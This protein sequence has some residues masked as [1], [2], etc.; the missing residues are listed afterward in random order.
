[1]ILIL[2]GATDG[3]QPDVCAVLDRKGAKYA[4]LDTAAFPQSV[5]VT[6]RYSYGERDSASLQI[7]EQ[8]IDLVQVRAVWYRRPTPP[9][10]D[11]GLAE[12]DRQ[13]VAREA[14]HVFSGLWHSLRNRFWVNPYDASRAVEH[15]PYQLRMA[16]DVGFDVPRTLITNEPHEALEFFD[17]CAEGMIYKTFSGHARITDDT[18]YAI[19]TS[20][21]ARADLVARC[22][23]I[24]L[25]PCIFQEYVPKKVELR[26]TVIGKRIFA[27]E[28]DSQSRERT[29]DDWRRDSL[30]SHPAMWPTELPP[31]QQTLVHEMMNR[32]GL[33]FGCFD[34]VRTPD[35][36]YVFL[37]LNPNG[38]W[39]WIEQYTGAP[40]MDSFTDMLIRGTPAY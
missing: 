10:P 18:Y 21:V 15:K 12:Q 27:T 40:L 5:G 17:S 39:F 37:E 35:D 1:V 29:K 13:F 7:A 20:R 33:V 24:Q 11:P 32:M 9:V 28:I 16:R 4:R 34:F 36:R 31:R 23:E 14:Q 26:V 8:L 2:T 30:V 19:F 38:Q 3:L 6:L 22:R 25:C